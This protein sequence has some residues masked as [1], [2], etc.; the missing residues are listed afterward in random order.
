MR[1][2]VKITRMDHT[3]S[4]LRGI[5]AKSPDG[6]QVRRL[7]ALALILEGH[8]REA[9][10]ALAGMDWQTL[11]DWVHRY[12]AEGVSGLCSIRTGRHPP[13]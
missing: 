10:A 4:V 13:P 12:N 9:A 11:R 7:L 8:R 5:A 2:G 1:A 6:A 3:A